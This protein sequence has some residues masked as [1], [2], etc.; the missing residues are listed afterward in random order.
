MVASTE[1]GSDQIMAA[2]QEHAPRLEDA[3]DFG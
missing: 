2:E 3:E 1:N